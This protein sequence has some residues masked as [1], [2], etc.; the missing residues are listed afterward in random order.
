MRQHP[1]S[2]FWLLALCFALLSTPSFAILRELN[3]SGQVLDPSGNPVRF[4]DPLTT[5][6]QTEI[7]LYLPSELRFYDSETASVAFLTL[8]QSARVG[9]GI[10]QI[11]FYPP[12]A[13]AMR[14][15]VWYEVSIDLNRNG[16]DPGD[17]FNARAA[18]GA[19]PYALSTTPTESYVVNGGV[20]GYTSPLDPGYL[21]SCPFETPPGGIRFDRMI[22]PIQNMRPGLAFSIGIFTSSGDLLTS[23]GLIFNDLDKSISHGYAEAELPPCALMPSTRYFI[24]V[25]ATGVQLNNGPLPPSPTYGHVTIS[26]QDGSVP[27]SFDPTHIVPNYYAA[28]IT[29]TLTNSDATSASLTARAANG[30][31]QLPLPRYRFILPGE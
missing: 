16:L 2:I 15:G 22:I 12:A 21:F 25:S 30:A 17:S 1:H 28:A 8:R 27:S 9:F 6:T 24:G 19:V 29:V 31:K 26:A 4:Y 5:Q 10:F 14:T 18:L 11:S 3:V 23:T 13:L 7:S 20:V